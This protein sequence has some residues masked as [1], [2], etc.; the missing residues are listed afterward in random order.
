LRWDETAEQMK[1]TQDVEYTY[2]LGRNVTQ[3]RFSDD[4]GWVYTETRSYARGYQ[5]TDFSEEHASG[6]TVIAAGSYTYD[7]NNN[8]AGT[9]KF[10]VYRQGLPLVQLAYRAGWTFTFDRKNRLKSH[11]HNETDDVTHLWWDGLGR[12]WQRWDYD[13][14]GELWSDYLTRFVYDGGVLAQEHLFT[15]FGESSWDYTYVHLTHDYLRQP[16]GTRDRKATNGGYTDYFLL[17]DGGTVSGQFT[18]GSSLSLDK[19]QR[20]IAGNRQARYSVAGGPPTTGDFTDV[21]NF[22]FASTYIESFG[23]TKT[24]DAQFFDALNQ[25]GDRHLLVGIDRWLTLRGNNTQAG[26]MGAV[27]VRPS[28]M[29]EGPEIMPSRP[30]GQGELQPGDELEPQATGCPDCCWDFFCDTEFRASKQCWHK[31]CCGCFTWSTLGVYPCDD[32]NNRCRE[33]CCNTAVYEGLRLASGYSSG[34]H[35]A[36]TSR[37]T[38]WRNNWD[39]IDIRWEGRHNEKTFIDV[40]NLIETLCT[41]IGDSGCLSLCPGKQDRLCDCVRMFCD[42]IYLP[43]IRIGPWETHHWTPF[44][45]WEIRLRHSAEWID[46]L[47]ELMHFCMHHKGLMNLEARAY[48]CER[49]CAGQEWNK[50]GHIDPPYNDID[51]CCCADSMPPQCFLKYTGAAEW[52]WEY[53]ML[54]ESIIAKP[55]E[56]IWGG[57]FR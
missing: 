25:F 38:C 15:V 54:I 2:D 22:G 7:A 57:W 40:Q 44:S 30:P 5:L 18:R 42:C 19:A 23:G 39:R 43:T 36:G 51:P 56:W 6:V 10:S 14:G 33:K 16:A 34:Q 46:L 1:V 28:G 17:T 12:V 41:K 45:P 3:V 29:L 8:M 50:W 52:Y 35:C 9:K 55:D 21:S 13:S 20:E 47:H 26:H 49:A 4:E 24:G 32:P 37:G 31:W 53:L 27:G 11:T 48:A